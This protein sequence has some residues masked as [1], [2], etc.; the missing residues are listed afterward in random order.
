MPWSMVTR[1]DNL[2][3]AE[4]DATKKGVLTTLKLEIDRIAK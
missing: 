2:I 1:L 3:Q 4:A